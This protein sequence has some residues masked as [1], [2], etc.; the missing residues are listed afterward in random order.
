MKNVIIGYMSV[1]SEHMKTY[2]TALVIMEMHIKITVQGVLVV[3][4]QKQI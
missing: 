1:A 2:R 3:A 4:Q